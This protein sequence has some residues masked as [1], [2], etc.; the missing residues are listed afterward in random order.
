MLAYVIYFLIVSII[1]IIPIITLIL[2]VKIYKKTKI[3]I[4]NI[5]LISVFTILLIIYISCYRATGIEINFT[6]LE[7]GFIILST[8]FIISKYFVNIWLL[9]NNYKIQKS[10]PIVSLSINI[11][12]ILYEILFLVETMREQY[13][14][15]TKQ[16]GEEKDNELIFDQIDVKINKNN[17]NAL[18]PSFKAKFNDNNNYNEQVII[19]MFDT[20][21]NKNDSKLYFKLHNKNNHVYF[22]EIQQE[23]I[24]E[25]ETNLIFT[26]V[27]LSPEEQRNLTIIDLL[28]EYLSDED[29]FDEKKK[30]PNEYDVVYLP[31]CKKGLADVVFDNDIKEIKKTYIFSKMDDDDIFKYIKEKWELTVGWSEFGYTFQPTRDKSKEMKNNRYRYKLYFDDEEQEIRIISPNFTEYIK[32][33]KDRLSF[34]TK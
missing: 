14:N 13:K 6:K 27:N 12:V 19:K 11:I 16:E 10:I 31:Y 7:I 23:T 20:I 2:N 29:S 8:V 17:L 1:G 9:R 25:N 32:K 18:L 28:D 30:D 4:T 26:N 3:V 22:I 34:D 21:K 24:K 33:I 15:S 5:I